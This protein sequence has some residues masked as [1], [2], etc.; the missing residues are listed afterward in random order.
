MSLTTAYF[1]HLKTLNFLTR[2]RKKQ[3]Q[4]QTIAGTAMKIAKKD[5]LEL[6][7]LLSDPSLSNIFC[8]TKNEFVRTF[9][10]SFSSSIETLNDSET[11][12]KITRYSN[13]G[14]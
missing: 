3:K 5:L 1:P 14:N 2:M 10:N 9:P 8:S 4:T 12:A 13:V 6:I 11:F 7:S